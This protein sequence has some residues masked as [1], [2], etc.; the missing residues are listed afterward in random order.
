MAIPLETRK[1]FVYE[2]VER[3]DM[4][5]FLSRDPFRYLPFPLANFPSRRNPDVEFAQNVH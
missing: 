2:F 1:L 3:F 5:T 4:A